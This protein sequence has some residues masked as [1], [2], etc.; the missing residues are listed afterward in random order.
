MMAGAASQTNRL[1]TPGPLGWQE[2]D[3]ESS[4]VFSVIQLL[5]RD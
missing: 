2:G 1:H 3:K 4:F 5:H